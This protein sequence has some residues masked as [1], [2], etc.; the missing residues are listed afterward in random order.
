MA[1]QKVLL[2]KVIKS[3]FNFCCAAIDAA[4]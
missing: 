4:L 1:G 2:Q 3:G